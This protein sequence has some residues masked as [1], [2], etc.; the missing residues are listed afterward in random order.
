MTTHFFQGAVNARI[1][2]NSV[3]QH[4][5]GNVNNNYVNCTSCQKR[6]VDRIMPKQSQFR[7]FFTGDVFLREETWLQEVDVV[8]RRPSTNP[9]RKC[10]ETR[11]KVVKRCHTAT[12]FPHSEQTFTVI[13]LEPKDE[14]DRE[15]TCLVSRK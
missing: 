11:V 4:I 10:V 12:I 5:E 3:F 1:G 14:R 13:A 8:I 15:T 6:E 7:E 2:R 9:F